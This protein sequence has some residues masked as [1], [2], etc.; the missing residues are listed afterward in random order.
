MLIDY[1]KHFPIPATQLPLRL[2][3]LLEPVDDDPQLRVEVSSRY[4]FDQYGPHREYVHMV[5]T[6]VPE[7]DLAALGILREASD[8]VVTS[9][10]PDVGEQ[11]GLADFTPSVSGFDYIVAS[12]RD[13]SFYSYSLAEKV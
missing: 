1:L 12:L 4:D 6:L 5:M 2:R 13:R 3:T 8:G 9:S 10:T 7:P 11:G